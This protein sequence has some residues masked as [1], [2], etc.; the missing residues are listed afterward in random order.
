MHIVCTDLE[1]VLV[2]EIWINVAA[3]TGIEELQLTTRDISNYD[4]LMKKRLAILKEH[5]ISLADIQ[6][7]I[8]T[9][10]PLEGALAYLNWLRER[11][12]VVLVSDTFVEFARPL[13]AKLGWPTLFCNSLTVDGNGAVTDYNLRQKDGKRQVVLA[14]KA[15][16]YKV[17]G[18]GDSYNDMTMLKEAHH[19]VLFRPPQNVVAEFPQYPVTRT[20]QEAKALIGKII[21][22]GT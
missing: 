6:A 14:L 2:P 21:E 10:V 13:M 17:I 5:G 19:G 11:V 1:G 8:E 9:M 15:L 22:A 12:Q 7:V 20:Y 16:D 4:V 18:L 3:K